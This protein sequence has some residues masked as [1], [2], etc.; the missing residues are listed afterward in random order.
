MHITLI[1]KIFFL[2]KYINEEGYLLFSPLKTRKINK[3]NLDINN[4]YAKFYSK[5]KRMSIYYKIILRSSS[6]IKDE[7][8]GAIN[9][10]PELFIQKK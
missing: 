9:F 1:K 10:A 2:K 5:N 4:K 6:T 8:V 3:L 7:N